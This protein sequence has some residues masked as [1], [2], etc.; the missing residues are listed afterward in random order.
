[1]VWRRDDAFCDALVPAKFVLHKPR[2]DKG[3]FKLYRIR[4]KIRTLVNS[5]DPD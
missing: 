5:G 3:V 4:P 2:K 1:V